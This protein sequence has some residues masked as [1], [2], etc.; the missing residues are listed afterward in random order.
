PG[1][2]GDA[3]ADHVE[4]AAAEVHHPVA[5]LV[6]DVRVPDVPLV[7]DRPIEHPGPARHLVDLERDLL[8]KAGK[9]LPYAVSGDAP[10]DRVQFLDGRVHRA[11]GLEVRSAHRVGRKSGYEASRSRMIGSGIGHSMPN[12]GSFHRT[13]RACCG[14]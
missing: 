10:A 9:G 14:E 11:A 4:V 2:D 5:V 12:A 6:L 1:P 7:R 3:V 8:S 13:P